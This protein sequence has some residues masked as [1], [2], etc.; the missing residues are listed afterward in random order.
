[1]SICSK[2]YGSLLKSAS[3]WPCSSLTTQQCKC[4]HLRS[5]HSFTW[6]LGFSLPNTTRRS[7]VRH[8]ASRISKGQDKQW[9]C[10][11][12][13]ETKPSAVCV[14]HQNRP[15]NTILWLA[16]RNQ[17][18]NTLTI[19][20][21]IS[22][23][24]FPYLLP[25]LSVRHQHSAHFHSYRWAPCD[26]FYSELLLFFVLITHV[27]ICSAGAFLFLLLTARSQGFL[28]WTHS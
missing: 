11:S 19:K 13:P 17:T 21:Q 9:Q 25:H 26:F 10:Q 3:W 1:M 22:L 15:S 27:W 12:H 24:G 28:W 16:L 8:P 23:R 4:S 5:R 18:T 14:L 6:L 7:G 2:Q 20:T